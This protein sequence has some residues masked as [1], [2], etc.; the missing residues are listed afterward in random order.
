MLQPELWAATA[1]LLLGAA[2][3]L[4]IR[5]QLSATKREAEL[6]E[7]RSQLE[8]QPRFEVIRSH[9]FATR[10]LEKSKEPE[11]LSIAR[12]ATEELSASHHPGYGSRDEPRY[13]NFLAENCLQEDTAYVEPMSLHHYYNCSRLFSPPH[14][15]SPGKQEKDE[16][17]YSYENVTIGVSQG[18]DPDD[19]VDYENSMTIL[20]W[21]LQQG[22][23]P[24]TESLDDEPDY[25]NTAP[26][27]GPAL[28]PEQ[29]ILHKV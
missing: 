22:Q 10:R 2:V 19:A 3:S 1:L 7:Q 27:S 5:C 6:D 29:S 28:L 17:S 9:T 14:A 25:I 8:S 24:V 18:S 21:K 26:V 23:A 13:Q 15:R 12:K 20:T 16:D 4:C 11:N